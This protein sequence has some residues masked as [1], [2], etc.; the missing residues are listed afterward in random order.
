[1]SPMAGVVVTSTSPV[2]EWCSVPVLPSTT[3]IV[4]GL[5]MPPATGPATTTASGTSH[6]SISPLSSS[7]VRLATSGVT[8]L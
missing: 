3:Q 1:M 6:R 5:P 2:I 7:S 4:P 8:M